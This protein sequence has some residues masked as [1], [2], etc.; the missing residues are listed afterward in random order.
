MK[1]IL[2]QD[3]PGTGKKNQ[4]VNVSDG[5]ARNFLFPR[6]VAMEA[7][8]GAVS[9]VERR[10]EAERQREAERRAEAEKVA[11]SLKGKV[12]TIRSK[13]GDKGRLYGSV[14]TQE[15]ADALESQHGVAVDKRK[16]DLKEPIRTLGETMVG[17]W[18]YSGLTISMKVETVAAEQ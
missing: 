14:T 5:Y 4:I 16:I 10:N 7:T 9:E 11:A 18:L 12:I 1:V 3:V 8:K 17:V 6:K 13:A 15:I 2:L